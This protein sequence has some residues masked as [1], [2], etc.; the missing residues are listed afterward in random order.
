MDYVG[1]P[2]LEE[3]LSDIPREKIRHIIPEVA[4][5]A[6]FL[7]GTLGHVHRDIKPPNVALNR[8]TFKVTLLD[9]GLLRPVVGETVTDQAPRFVATK[10]YAPPE[11]LNGTMSR[12]SD[13]WDAVS[14]YQ[15][16]GILYSLAMRK[17]LFDGYDG[18]D[19][20]RAIQS[21][22]PQIDSADVPPD[23][24]Q[25]ARDCLQKSAAIRLS[26]VNWGRFFAVPDPNA[27][28]NEIDRLRDAVRRLPPRVPSERFPEG[29][30]EQ[31][32]AATAYKR[33]ELAIDYHVR[34]LLNSDETLFP[35]HIIVLDKT[36]SQSFTLRATITYRQMP[37]DIDVTVF[38][39][40]HLLDIASLLCTCTLTACLGSIET[41]PTSASGV[42]FFK[43]SFVEGAFSAALD[44][45]LPAILARILNTQDNRGAP[46]QMGL[47]SDHGAK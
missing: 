27:V 37:S 42:T 20:T 9:L 39:S 2:T 47:V 25:L 24:I 31:H 15:L 41:I 16:G 3:V 40:C 36:S 1:D 30:K 46:R 26:L 28:V 13:G 6:V 34:S 14:Y 43:G 5:A 45:E 35:Q 8:D 32:A 23:L 38:L 7:H 10:R 12:D 4:K 17:P 11:F 18:D 21:E 22:V 19:L 44:V 33:I 29:A